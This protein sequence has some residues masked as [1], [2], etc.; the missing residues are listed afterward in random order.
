MRLDHTLLPLK[1]YHKAKR[2]MWDPQEI[3]FTQDKHDWDAMGEREHALITRSIALFIG[4]EAAVT[5]DLSPLLVALKRSGGRIE[6]AMFLT[7]QLFE[8]AKHVEFFDRFIV[9]VLGEAPD[10]AQIAGPNYR[11]LFGAL[12][13]A[14]DT[15]L[16]DSGRPAQ[17]RAVASYHMIIEGVLA[18]TGYYAIFKALREKDLMPG[19]TSGLELLQRDESRHIAFGLYLLTRLLREDALLWSVVEGQLNALLP[20]AQGVFMELLSD[21]LPNIPFDLD[22]NDVIGYAGRQY[23]AR[24]AVLE[25]ARQG[26]A[27]QPDSV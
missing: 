10:A 19:L 5:D 8:E 21:F 2:L 16:T 6:E 25:R 3:D 17:A 22:L 9:K 20:L 24:V 26:L 11:A 23:M 13:Q 1:D 12:N 15:L 27:L 18:E 14:L 7:T 4:G